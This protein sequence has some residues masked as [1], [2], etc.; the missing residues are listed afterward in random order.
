M[1]LADADRDSGAAPFLTV[2]MPVH[3]GERWIEPTLKSLAAEATDDV[4]VLVIDSSPDAGTAEMVR[5]FGAGLSLELLTRPDLSNWR[6]K[7][8]FGV[9]HARGAHVC[10][11][12]QDDLWLPGRVAAIRDWIASAPEAAL[13]LAPTTII[14][15]DGNPLGTWRCPLPAEE[16]VTP[17]LVL[18]RLLVQN[19]IAVPSPVFRRDAWLACGGLDLDLWYTADWDLWLKL[20][21][22]GPVRYH[23]TVT[24]AFR[25]HGSSLTVTGSRD[26]ADFEDQMRIVLDRHLSR[27]SPARAAAVGRVAR[28][29]IK[30]NVALAAASS[31]GLGALGR[32]ACH[33]LS[34][35]PHGL[36]RYLRDSRLL[37]RVVPR[38]RAKLSGAL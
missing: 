23:E 5:R 4:E 2:V 37:E 17:A 8:N 27:L 3:C 16:A 38:L 18:E 20:A 19:F 6:T 14:D 28:A 26:S 32:A 21:S 35:G 36:Y 29:S 15:Q 22:R 33:M 9:E 24:A 25:I 1:T 13:H 7:T 11:L 30:V 31:G 10:T 12:H 34:L